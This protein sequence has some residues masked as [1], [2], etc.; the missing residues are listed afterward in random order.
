MFSGLT[1][2]G[3]VTT[4][5]RINNP[6]NSSI[7]LLHNLVSFGEIQMEQNHNVLRSLE[8]FEQFFNVLHGPDPI[9][10]HQVV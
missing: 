10:G 2:I 8:D 5:G 3:T 4:Y 9:D 1:I 6:L 7:S